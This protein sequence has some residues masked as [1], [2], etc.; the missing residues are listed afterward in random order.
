M[1]NQKTGV[2]SMDIVHRILALE[3]IEEAKCLAKESLK[4]CNKKV[5]DSS[6]SKAV[7]MVDKSKSIRNIAF[8]MSNF[9]LAFQNEKVIK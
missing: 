5:R 2:F 6:I 1:Q 7:S 8:G 4:S 3:C 9:I